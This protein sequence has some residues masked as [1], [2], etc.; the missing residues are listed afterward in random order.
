[1]V[2]VPSADGGVTLEPAVT[3]SACTSRDARPF[4]APPLIA[5]DV[6]GNGG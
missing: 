5:A 4:R 2:A 3:I 1:M 6:D